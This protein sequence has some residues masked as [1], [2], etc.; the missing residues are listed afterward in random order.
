[1][2]TTILAAGLLVLTPPEGP[3]RYERAFETAKRLE[4]EG[5]TPDLVFMLE[6]RN[7]FSWQ[8]ASLYRVE[9]GLRE[10]RWIVRR[11]REGD[12]RWGDGRDGPQTPLVWA[13]SR[14]C[15]GV[16]SVLEGVERIQL[17]P[18]DVFRIGTEYGAN[19]DV[20]VGGAR[21]TFWLEGA[22]VTPSVQMTGYHYLGNWWSD[23]H[24]ALQSCWTTTRPRIERED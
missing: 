14:N 2:L 5:Y 23:G 3:S 1:M 8:I 20:L 6:S 22:A 7:D 18:L 16:L 17:M 4:V 12:A 9:P 10:N 24:E 13:D 11:Q 15:P 21:M 19:G